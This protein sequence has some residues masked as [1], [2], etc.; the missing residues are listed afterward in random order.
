MVNRENKLDLL[1]SEAPDLE[2]KLFLKSFM[3]RQDSDRYVWYLYVC[4]YVYM[5]T[6]AHVVR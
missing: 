4:A 2:T 1:I 6:H 5:S 3:A